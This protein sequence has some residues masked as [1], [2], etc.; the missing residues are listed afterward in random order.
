MDTHAHLS[1][2]ARRAADGDEAALEQLLGDLLPLVVRAARLVVGPG[3]WAAEDA[4]QEAMLD[5]TRGI[6]TLRHPEAVGA[7]AARI[8]ARQALKAARRERFGR[9]LER[10]E[11]FMT[12]TPS[13]SRSR[14]LKDAFYA[15]PP[16]MR[17]IAVLRLY[18]GLS[19][20]ETAAALGCSVGT[21][22]S[23]LSESRRRLTQSLTAEGLAPRKQTSN[24]EGARR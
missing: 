16:R 22:K 14:A 24:T 21:V 3:S 4:A 11:A 23:Q 7:W 6:K 19:E 8:A 5:V 18:V 17:A 9:L 20:Q 2:L 13:D 12:E 15:L 10:R 1:A